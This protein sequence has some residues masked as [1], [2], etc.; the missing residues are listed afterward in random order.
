MLKI[1]LLAL[2]DLKEKGGLRA[3]HCT[4]EEESCRSGQRLPAGLL[5]FAKASA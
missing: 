2:A 1:R 5:S 4:G 3:L